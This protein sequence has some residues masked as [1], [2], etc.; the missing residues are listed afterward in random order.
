MKS[1]IIEE[2]GQTELLLPARIAEGLAANDRVK[3]RLSLLQAAASHARD[4]HGSPFDLE[5]ECLGAGLDAAA[6][7]RLVGEAARA[8]ERLTAPG[9]AGLVAAVW[10]D[11]GVMASAVGA[12]D[13]AEEA[14]ARARMA[15]MRQGGA[16]EDAA[17]SAGDTVDFS[18][19]T[20]LTA[21][22][23]GEADTLHRLIMDLHKTLN[24]LAALHAE[25]E[26]AGAHVHGLLP[27]DRPAVEAF[28]QGVASTAKL[29][30]G[31]PGLAT[32]AARIGGRFTIQNDIGETDAHVVVIEV[33]ADAV[34]VIYTDVHLPRA[35]FFTGLFNNFAVEWSGL[36][37][38]S[39]AG[40]ADEGVFYMITG[41]CPVGSDRSR[42]TFLEAVGSSLVFLIDWNKARR[43]LRNWV[44]K[45]DAVA[46]LDW[47]ARNRIG[48]R[49][50]L[51]LG[52][53][54]FLAAAVRHAASSRIGFGE[55]LERVLGRAAAIDFLKAV[56]RI[57]TDALLHGNSVRL[58]RDRIEAD[59]MRHLQRTDVALLAVV[60]RQAGLAREI[61]AAIAHFLVERR[62]RRRFDGAAMAR[63]AQ[64]IEEKADRIAMEARSEI[65]R[66][67]ADR[68]IEV[69]VNRMEDAIDELEQAAFAASLL[70][71][72]IAPVL[73]DALDALCATVVGGTGAA[74]SGVAAAAEVPEGHRIDSEDALAAVGRLTEAEHDADICERKVTAAILTGDFDLKIALSVIELA[75][76]LE[77]A[78]DRLA[79]FGHGLREHVLAELAV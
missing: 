12:A 20:K 66:L 7:R 46:I 25:E 29:K 9:L 36:E 17:A 71:T 55:S 42:D 43:T 18:L 69:L 54:D 59:F 72:A 14:R 8:G 45:R 30:F 57:S 11:V 78:T 51:E 38:K 27:Q 26:I 10:N 56:L 79:A 53:S 47:A 67:D 32:T 75:R 52:G 24:A 34:T 21:I 63:Q 15:A 37:R 58:V 1:E 35:R 50:F 13:R 73:L 4:P 19:V 74:A 62:N 48:H 65:A 28:M 6:M 77:R 76:A 60:I 22:S 23:G 70:P 5:A 49:A 40:L 31:H 2:L 39:A 68:G 61:G 64:H 16:S 3:V 44:P 41:R 33:G